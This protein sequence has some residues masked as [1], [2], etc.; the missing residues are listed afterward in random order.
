MSS[1]STGVAERKVSAPSSRRSESSHV[2]GRVPTR[3]NTPRWQDS[4]E[5]NVIDL[6]EARRE[7]LARQRSSPRPSQELRQ[8]RRPESQRLEEEVEQ[9]SASAAPEASIQNSK[10]P[11][12]HWGLILVTILLSLAS[13]PMIYSA[14]Q[15][16]ALDNHGSTDYFLIRQIFFV[17]SGL[18]IMIGV[19]RMPP[20][21]MRGLAW[22]IY[23]GAIVGLIATKFTP[24]GVTMGGVERWLKVGPVP[25]QVSEIA[26]FALIGVLADFWSRASVPSQKSKWP[27]IAAFAIAGL[28]IILVFLQ[29]HL[30]AT[31]VLF[32]LPIIIGFYAGAP[33]KQIGTLMGGL[34][35]IGLL[36]I[37]LCSIKKMPFLPMYQQE[38]IAHFLSSETDEKGAHY[39]TEQGLRAIERGGLTGAG[40]GGSL[41]KQGHLPA[42][43]TDF[44]LAVIGEETG[45]LG[46]VSLLVLYGAMIFFCF[47]IGHSATK[48]FETLLCAG[49]GSL[50]ALQVICNLGVVLDVMPVTG[51]PLPMMSYGGSGLLCTL[52]GIGWVLG[53]SRNG[54]REENAPQTAM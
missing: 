36:V 50:L 21:Y 54:A 40:P 52:L 6:H 18:G 49:V 13:I 44:I 46:M 27:W 10:C 41:F 24:L 30:S 31:L 5:D 25:L 45:L 37:G 16:I 26:K 3:R 39:Q 17:L 48:P 43:H 34:A 11:P 15:A 38:R 1:S 2:T 33:I 12:C 32:A 19:S 14:S 7:R 28:P 9:S 51:M 47:Q 23:A 35:V 42:P 29:P 22:G 53:V 20:K 4:D 8:A